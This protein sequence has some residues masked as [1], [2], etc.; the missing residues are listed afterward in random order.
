MRLLATAVMLCGSLSLANAN[1]ALAIVDVRV[2]DRLKIEPIRRF[3]TSKLALLRACNNR[4]KATG[5]LTLRL[6]INASGHVIMS[7]VS[8]LGN[9][10]VE[11]CVEHVM[12]NSRFPNPRN[13]TRAWVT[14]KYD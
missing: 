12:R 6:M 3:V 13:M 14:L 5:T 2:A 1:S 10:K 8:D 9:E 7:E 11:A 4:E